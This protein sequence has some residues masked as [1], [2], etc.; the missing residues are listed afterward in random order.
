ME[1]HEP[2]AD[3]GAASCA[4]HDGAQSTGACARCGNFVC[5]LCLDESSGLPGHCAACREREGGGIIAF[6]RSEGGLFRRWWQT[7]KDMLL[8]PTRTFETV[9]PGSV[10]AAAGFVG[11]TGTIVGGSV[12]ALGLC[13]AGVVA[14]LGSREELQLSGGLGRNWG[15]LLVALASYVVL[16]PVGLLIGGFLRACVFHLAAVLLGA[17]RGFGVSL[18]SMSYLQVT[19]ITLLPLMF[20]RAVPFLG[21]ILGVVGLL[22]IEVFYATQ[23]TT[24]ARRYH[25]LSEGRASMAGWSIFVCGVAFASLCCLLGVFAATAR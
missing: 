21:D 14:G 20:V 22:A 2:T 24:V 3:P 19:A 15:I 16:M 13:L 10:V 17:R 11:L 7:S 5:P 8:R 12:S 9:R 6:E 1:G 23:L 25:G 18:W 4:T